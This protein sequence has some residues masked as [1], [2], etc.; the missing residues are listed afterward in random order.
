MLAIKTKLI[1]NQL[2]NH[3]KSAYVYFE[4]TSVYNFER[5]KYAKYIVNNVPKS[6]FPKK[7]RAV[8]GRHIYKCIN[9]CLKVYVREY[10]LT[11]C[12]EIIIVTV[13]AAAK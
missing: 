8:N 9:P 3:K 13:N 4:N 5:A 6:N 11:K 10:G 1:I 2:T 7:T 12:N